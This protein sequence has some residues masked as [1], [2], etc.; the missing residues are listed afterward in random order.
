MLTNVMEEIILGL[1]SVLLRGTEY[2]TFCKCSKC[3]KDIVLVNMLPLIL[4]EKL[5]SI[6]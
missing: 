4:E 2:Q 1:V 6:N 5:H 3:E